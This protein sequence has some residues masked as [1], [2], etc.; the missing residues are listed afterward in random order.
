MAS[1]SQLI[2]Y[3]AIIVIVIALASIGMKFTGFA[4]AEDT[5]VVN[6][7]IASSAA[8]NFTT[9][10][11]S[12]GSG[13][14]NTGEASATVSTDADTVTGT[15]QNTT[16]KLVLENIGNVD[17]ALGLKSDKVASD[18]IGGTSPS[19]KYKV[20]DTCVKGYTE[21]LTSEAAICPFPFANAND[22]ITL[23]IKMLIPSDAIPGS[24]TA[25]ITAVGTYT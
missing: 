24:K 13:S 15:W 17:V 18:L 6:I 3:A 10:F 2:G 21:F 20:S 7:T 11:I 23:D 1:K 4:T 16:P 8:I 14:V 12:F 22:S 25:I 5:A 19:F 9:D